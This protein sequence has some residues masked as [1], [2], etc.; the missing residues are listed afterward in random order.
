M[1][2]PFTQP[3]VYPIRA[4]CSGSKGESAYLPLVA[5]E[6]VVQQHGHVRQHRADGTDRQDVEVAHHAVKPTSDEGVRV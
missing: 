3:Y 2:G 1:E 5:V 6:G 4:L